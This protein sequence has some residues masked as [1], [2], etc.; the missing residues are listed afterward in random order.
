[1]TGKPVM[2]WQAGNNG[3]RITIHTIILSYCA[4]ESSE[5]NFPTQSFGINEH[6]VFTDDETPVIYSRSGNKTHCAFSPDVNIINPIT[7][8]CILFC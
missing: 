6:S 3:K 8:I 1:M 5:I 4:G 2:L 7:S